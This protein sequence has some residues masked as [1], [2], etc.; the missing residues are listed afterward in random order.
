MNPASEPT[1]NANGSFTFPAWFAHR[2]LSCYYGNGPKA[3]GIPAARSE[4][5]A[6]EP[7]AS[8]TPS[9]LEGEF[10]GGTVIDL[11]AIPRG[12]VPKGYAAKTQVKIPPSVIPAGP[13]VPGEAV[14]IKVGGGV[15]SNGH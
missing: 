4:Q 5:Q 14:D 2:L 6:Q 13:Y 9:T 15:T 3:D 8:P 11:A 10:A 7:P 12:Y 1:I